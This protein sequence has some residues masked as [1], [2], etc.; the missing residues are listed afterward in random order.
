M[1]KSTTATTTTVNLELH[2]FAYSCSMT[3]REL[4]KLRN[5]I[6]KQWIITTVRD[7][8]INMEYQKGLQFIMYVG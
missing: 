8:C 3:D 4:L 2:F 1:N 5:D 7:E 6:L